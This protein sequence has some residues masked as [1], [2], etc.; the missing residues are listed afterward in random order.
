MEI[1]DLEYLVASAETQNFGRAAEALGLNTSTISRRI[2]QLEDELG[3]A[4]FERGHS[5]VRP[6]AGGK[7]VIAYARRA[8]AELTSLRHT[9]KQTGSGHAGQI[10][11]GVWLPPIGEPLASLLRRWREGHANVELTISEMNDRALAV[12][13][14]ERQLDVALTSSHT[15]LPHIATLSL[16]RDR[17]VVALPGGHAL[18]R[19]PAVAW[20][21][22]R[23]EAVLFQEWDDS[24]ATREFYKGL[25]GQSANLKP[26]PASKL[27]VLALVAA[28][29]GIAL[30]TAGQSEVAFPGVVYKPIEDHDAQIQFVLAWLPELEDAAVGRFVAFLRDETRSRNL[31]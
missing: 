16:F 7:S 11:L 4:L 8:L 18:A 5:G 14:R 26:H 30:A 31:I 15:V 24:Q 6:T 17:I 1:R 3:L 20:A 22:L 21:A 2:A 19:Q 29:F 27:S 25:L 10:R 23:D 9:G 13:L 12:A 28:G